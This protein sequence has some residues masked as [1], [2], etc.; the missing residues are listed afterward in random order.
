MPVSV[1]ITSVLQASR[2]MTSLYEIV[3][4]LK[5]AICSLNP[6]VSSLFAPLLSTFSLS[7]LSKHHPQFGCCED[8]H[9]LF[10]SAMKVAFSA[11]YDWMNPSAYRYVYFTWQARCSIIAAA[12]PIGGRYDQSLTFAEN[13]RKS[14][15]TVL[16]FVSDVLFYLRLF[17]LVYQKT[18]S[19]SIAQI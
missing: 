1:V 9:A 5:I 6:L 3:F 13:V 12:N 11:V 15:F 8:G 7:I 4:C 16:V 10:A 19:P 18:R 2:D 14:Y 17:F